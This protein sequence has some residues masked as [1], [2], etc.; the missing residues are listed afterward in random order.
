MNELGRNQVTRLIAQT[1]WE[2]RGGEE[3][4]HRDWYDAEKINNQQLWDDMLA[5][6]QESDEAG[7][8]RIVRHIL[9]YKEELIRVI[10]I[11]D[12]PMVLPVLQ[13]AND[14]DNLMQSGYKGQLQCSLSIVPRLVSL[15]VES[16]VSVPCPIAYRVTGISASFDAVTDRNDQTVGSDRLYISTDLSFT[17]P[18]V[19]SR[20][21]HDD[22]S[23]AN[24]A[25]VFPIEI[26]ECQPDTYFFNFISH[27]QLTEIRYPVS[28]Y[29]NIEGMKEKERTTVLDLDLNA[30]LKV[31]RGQ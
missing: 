20:N 21:E 10:R 8:E 14:G 12:E 6:L 27:M 25:P 2:A 26:G 18:D 11:P 16:G 24:T 1:L 3:G 17:F 29:P 9:F 7:A 31:G 22:Q 15:G 19:D 4:N 5:V 28:S 13:L 23:G 30:P